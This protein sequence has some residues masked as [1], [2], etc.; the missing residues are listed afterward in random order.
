MDSFNYAN[1]IAENC[2][3]DEKLT[4]LKTPK[5]IVK[6]PL[7]V[8]KT[9]VTKHQPLSLIIHR[10]AKGNHVFEEVWRMEKKV[11][12][13]KKFGKLFEKELFEESDIIDE[14]KSP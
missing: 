2:V 6:S 5:N 11:D 14:P 9:V 3:L 12:G 8:K 13:K 7:H 10:D 1:L 4:V